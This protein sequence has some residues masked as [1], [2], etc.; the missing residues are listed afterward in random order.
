MSQMALFS[1]RLTSDAG[2]GS[3]SAVSVQL[4]YSSESATLSAVVNSVQAALT[5]LYSWVAKFNGTAEPT[6]VLHKQFLNTKITAQELAQY[7]DMYLKQTIDHDTYYDILYNGEVPVSV[8]MKTGAGFKPP[9][10]ATDAQAAPA[11]A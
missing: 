6:I 1:S 2:K 10:V 11:V 4:R 8:A 9:V 7:T 3:E 5:Q